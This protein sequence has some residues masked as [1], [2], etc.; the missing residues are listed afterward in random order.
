[1]SD[2]ILLTFSSVK[3]HCYSEDMIH[4]V[5]LPNAI[6][7]DQSYNTNGIWTGSKTIVDGVLVI[8]YTLELMKIIHKHNAKLAQPMLQIR[9]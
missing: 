7:P 4:C 1:M 2:A 9:H 6:A 8:I 5:R 3:G